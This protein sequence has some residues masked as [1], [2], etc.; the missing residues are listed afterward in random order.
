M[1]SLICAPAIST[2]QI[3]Y[4][5]VLIDE[6]LH[7]RKQAFPDKPLKPKHHY[8][9]HYPELIIHFGPLIRLWTLRFESKHTYFK[10]CARKLHNFKNLCLTLAERHQLPQAYL[11]AGD[12]FPP[13]VVVEKAAA[14]FPNDYNNTIKQSVSSYDFGPENTLIAHEATV[15]GTKYKKNMHVII[16]ESSR[17]LMIGKIIV[18]LIHNNSEVYYVTE[19]REA[20]L[21]HDL[22]VYGFTPI[23]GCY[24]C[25]KQDNLVDYYPL[26]EYILCDMPIIVPHHSFLSIESNDNLGGGAEGDPLQCLA[27]H[28]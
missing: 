5:R 18:V 9:S 27:N 3:A 6:Y 15:K 12:L 4:L 13:T 14:F 16:D 26:P 21:L 8:V 24:C 17:G 2:G 10:Q 20:L 7:F 25:V 23:Q 19:K 1:V 22:G 11:T 28:F